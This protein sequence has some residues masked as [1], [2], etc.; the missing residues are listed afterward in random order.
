M[1][2]S[3][4]TLSSPDD[5]RQ[6]MLAVAADEPG[7]FERLAEQYQP[8]IRG[9][10]RRFIKERTAVEDLSQ[11]VLLR[12]YRS[13]G[14]Y[15]P[16]AP[17]RAFL[18]RIIRNL[19]VNHMRYTRRRPACSLNDIGRDGITISESIPDD[20]S[21][22]PAHEA[23][24]NERALTIRAAIDRLPGNQR[25][26]LVLS[27]LHGLG[28]LEVAESIGLSNAAVKSL[29]WRGRENLARYLGSAHMAGECVSPCSRLARSPSKTCAPGSASMSASGR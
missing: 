27:S 11:E 29:L 4:S 18:Q 16:T 14:R 22:S 12:L 8:F 25:V 5:G 1:I 2:Q 15:Q 21:S 9:C 28:N 7:A 19:C 24:R 20:H 26:A 3:S 23:D 10:V 6:L 17:L 13:R